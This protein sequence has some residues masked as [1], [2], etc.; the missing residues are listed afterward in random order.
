MC[1]TCRNL[2]NEALNLACRSDQ[3]EEQRRRQ[4]MLDASIDGKAWVESKRFDAFI[5][6][7]N[8]ENPHARI[9]TRSMTMHL[10]MQ[11]QYDKD[12]ASWQ[13][14]ARRHLTRGCKCND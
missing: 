13:S 10:W 1:E 9:A 4:S 8:I 2:L 14:R 5:E 12:L 11:D 6:R 3:F 7:H